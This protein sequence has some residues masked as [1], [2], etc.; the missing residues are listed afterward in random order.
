MGPSFAVEPSSSSAVAGLTTISPASAAVSIRATRLAPGPVTMS[1]RKSLPTSMKSRSPE[2]M[3]IDI[4]SRT[5][6]TE[7]LTRP[8]R[9]MTRCISLAARAARAGWSSPWKSRSTA[10]PPHFTNPAPY[11]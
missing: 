7:V 9:S 10:S 3:P 8:M 1:S 4:R 6:P 5:V 11:S 2:W